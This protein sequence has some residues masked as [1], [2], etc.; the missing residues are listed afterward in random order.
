[1]KCNK[2]FLQLLNE[3]VAYL[4]DPDLYAM[5]KTYMK[6]KVDE[7]EKLIHTIC[8]GGQNREMTEVLRQEII[9]RCS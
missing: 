9:R 8:V 5:Y 2:L 1:M 3:E 4:E 7:D 6:R